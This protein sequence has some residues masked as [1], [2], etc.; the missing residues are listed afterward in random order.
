[1]NPWA[2][3]SQWFNVTLACVIAAASGMAWSAGM[4]TLPLPPNAKVGNL[5]DE[6][7]V[8]G[9]PSRLREVRVVGA[10]SVLID[11]YKS[12]LTRHASTPTIVQGDTEIVAGFVGRSYVTVIARNSPVPGQATAR[13]M[14]TDMS[15]RSTFD[16]R[17]GLPS[18]SEIHS[19]V[20]SHD[21][22]RVSSLVVFSNRQS[23]EANADFVV[24][25]LKQTMGMT[26]SESSNQEQHGHPAKLM[27]LTNDR[28]GD[29][30]LSVSSRGE[31]RYV[32]LNTMNTMGLHKP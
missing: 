29:A 28:G 15:K 9:L 18:G 22:G 13:V 27:Q 1:M 7:V 20:D 24:S 5:G 8:N 32:V 3:G 26:V 17:A 2:L 6:M 14:Q 21:G 31:R 12:N 19:Q 11:F 23:V 10:K 25:R 30:L 4:P 16:Y